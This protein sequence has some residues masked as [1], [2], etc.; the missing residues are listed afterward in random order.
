MT[1]RIIDDHEI[2]KKYFSKQHIN[3]L[4]NY[5]KGKWKIYNLGYIG[6]GNDHLSVIEIKNLATAIEVYKERENNMD[7]FKTGNGA[8]KYCCFN[9]DHFIHPK[10]NSLKY[11]SFYDSKH[12][13]QTISEVSN[14]SS[15]SI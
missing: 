3:F 11:N 12:S 14:S 15:E 10:N 7:Y 4:I 13:N 6:L 8:P 2:S 9:K 5:I 1:T